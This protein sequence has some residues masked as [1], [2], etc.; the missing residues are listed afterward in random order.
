MPCARKKS[1]SAYGATGRR[2][3]L[4]VVGGGWWLAAVGGWRELAVGGWWS[5][6][7]SLRAVLSK[8][9][10]NWSLKDR[11]AQALP[12]LDVWMWHDCCLPSC[13]G[14]FAIKDEHF[15]G[16]TIFSGAAI[17]VRGGGGRGYAINAE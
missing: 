10:K 17:A 15:L 9:K 3:R 12:C 2:W 5:L 7:R 13:H 1:F 11:P 6:G 4:A 16:A 14:G 8:K